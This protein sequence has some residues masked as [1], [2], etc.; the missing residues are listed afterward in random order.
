MGFLVLASFS[1]VLAQTALQQDDLSIL[2]NETTSK[3]D[4]PA[5]VIVISY[6]ADKEIFKV[7][8]ITVYGTLQSTEKIER[9]V[10]TVNEE[11]DFVVE[12]VYSWKAA[13]TLSPGVNN[14]VVRAI[15]VKGNSAR[16]SVTIS[17][18]PPEV[19]AYLAEKEVPLIL[20]S[21][22]IKRSIIQSK[23]TDVARLEEDRYLI[24]GESGQL[25]KA[26]IE[27]R[28]R[29][30]AEGT[31]PAEDAAAKDILV[32]E[33]T[34]VVSEMTSTEKSEAGLSTDEELLS[35]FVR[36]ESNLTNIDWAIIKIGFTDDEL[37]LKRLAREKLFMAWYDDN[38]ASQTF[39][40][41]VR[42][43]KGHPEWVHAVGINKTGMYVWANVSHF[44]VY[45][46]GGQIVTPT[47]T[48]LPT[49]PPPTTTPPTT[50]P[51]ETTAPTE[52][53][54][55]TQTQEPPVDTQPPTHFPKETPKPAVIAQ[56]T[57]T[58]AQILESPAP[59]R[60]VRKGRFL[61]PLLIILV[62]VA[63]L[64]GVRKKRQPNEEVAPENVEKDLLAEDET[65]P[66]DNP[67]K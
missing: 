24:D 37:K 50:A 12:G 5:L 16:E 46:I 39:G 44:S 11:R 54:T 28:L 45:G 43:R 36:V 67:D 6:P 19:V 7:D 21:E 2:S 59:V 66:D 15:D 48:P 30:Q 49:T 34:E 18:V 10:V 52:T 33:Y 60:N 9:L 3:S 4:A 8:T 32:E 25:K 58:P 47:P 61:I 51:P 31:A 26:A 13:V 40:K 64:T 65:P 63:I 23:L 29:R 41:W 14:I 55:P 17:Y 38:E 53:P 22:I 56:P 27:I 1:A 20:K 62:L 57:G 35:N 42:L